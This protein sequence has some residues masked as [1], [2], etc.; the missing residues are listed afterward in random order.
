MKKIALTSLLA[1]VAAAGAHAANTMDGNPLYMPK[2][3]HFY[4]ET[5]LESATSATN[6]VALGEEFGY[7]ITDRLSIGLTTS[8]AEDNWFDGN[9]WNEL[10][11]DLKWRLINDNAWKLDF[12]GAYAMNPVWGDHRP[13]MDKDDT[14][15]TWVAGLRGGYVTE[16]WTLSAHANFIYMNTESFN[17]GDDDAKVV[18]DDVEGEFWANHMLNLGVTGHWTMSDMWSAVASADYF[19][20]LDHY[21][22]VEN[23]GYWTIAA[24]LNMNLDD[25]KYVGA[26][27]SKDIKHTDAGEWTV[28]D[29]FGFGMKFGIDF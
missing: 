3:G 6:A 5:S 8:V 27:I 14:M 7:G 28:D 20:V 15:Y 10:G 23:R 24:G 4:S 21:N 26:Y 19:K 16:D 13:F 25:T 11:V 18:I 1:I 22:S 17:W 2:A 12:V 9:S 29:G